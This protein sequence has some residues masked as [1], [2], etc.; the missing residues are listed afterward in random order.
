MKKR[1]FDHIV[2]RNSMD[3]RWRSDAKTFVRVLM[4]ATA[5]QHEAFC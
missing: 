3:I 5:V 4:C 2:M 1:A